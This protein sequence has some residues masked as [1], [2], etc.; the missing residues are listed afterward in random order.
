M[1]KWLM[2]ELASNWVNECEKRED[3]MISQIR[4]SCF[5]FLYLFSSFCCCYIFLIRATQNLN[6]NYKTVV[7]SNTDWVE[8]N[9]RKIKN[10]VFFICCSQ[11]FFF[12]LHIPLTGFE[13]ISFFF[14]KRR[15]S[16][17]HFNLSLSIS[18]SLFLFSL[19][20]VFKR[21]NVF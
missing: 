2:I 12:I 5:F 8:S 15:I 7:Y 14:V 6:N 20:V 1:K 19:F 18:L 10:L 3:D 11:V 4:K 21:N 17:Y 13:C 16:I 9:S